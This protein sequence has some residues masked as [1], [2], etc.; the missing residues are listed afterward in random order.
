MK[1]TALSAPYNN[2]KI[3][4]HCCVDHIENVI[5]ELVYASAGVYGKAGIRNLEPEPETETEP[6]PDLELKLRPG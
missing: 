5:N 2:N 3:L 6:E 4:S 1:C